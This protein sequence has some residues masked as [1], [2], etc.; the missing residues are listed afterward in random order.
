VTE[1]RRDE[2]IDCAC[3]CTCTC[4][5]NA[6]QYTPS[7][8]L[9]LPAALRAGAAHVHV[10]A[11]PVTTLPPRFAPCRGVMCCAAGHA[12]PL[13]YV[14]VRVCVPR[15]ERE[16][17]REGGKTRGRDR[18]RDGMGWDGGRWAG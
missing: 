9:P 11:R 16:K 10:H 6:M 2:A 4:I 7:P 14:C 8:T 15:A 12:L 1:Q 17:R 3:T 18:R 13:P 5:C